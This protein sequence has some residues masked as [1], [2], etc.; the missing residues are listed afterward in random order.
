MRACPLF[1]YAHAGHAVGTRVLRLAVLRRVVVGALQRLQL[2]LREARAVVAHPQLR[3][4]RT[5]LRRCRRA[6]MAVPQ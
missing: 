5:P 1:A 4:G 2:A 3:R 6:T